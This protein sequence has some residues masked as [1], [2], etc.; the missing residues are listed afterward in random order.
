[1]H[2]DIRWFLG[3][4]IIMGIMAYIGWGAKRDVPP[5]TENRDS[6]TTAVTPQVSAPSETKISEAE[7][8]QEQIRKEQQEALK[9]QEEVNKAKEVAN[10]AP[11]KGKL[12]I[13]SVQPGYNRGTEYVV[14]TAPRE[15]SAPVIVTGLRVQG[16]RSRLSAEI[17]KGWKLPYPGAPK[18]GETVSLKPGEYAYI[19]TGQSANGQS[20]QLNKCTGYFEQGLDFTPSL[21]MSC[22]HPANEPL[23][24]PPNHLSDQCVDY[25]QT[26]PSCAT[27]S[28]PIPEYLQSDGTCQ[29]YL[30]NNTSYDR[31]VSLH[32]NDSDFY[33]GEWRLYL[34]RG[35]SLWPL[36][37][38]TI[39][40]ID[41][42]GK[43]ISS[44]SY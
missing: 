3:F 20:F 15:N 4:L 33:Q 32:K 17:P 7:Q 44:Y 8:R 27:Y 34:G 5:Q 31:C 26:L 9:L 37:Y 23:P 14:I 28:G 18:E 6:Q 40:L 29:N 10:A 36:R 30:F 1:M 38:D 12:F 16:V 42:E 24:E 25:L 39:E 41:Q 43:L 21:P 35:G 11:L 22:P 19:I 2:E 13:Q